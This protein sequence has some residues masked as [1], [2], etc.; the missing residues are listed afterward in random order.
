MDCDNCNA[1]S[2]SGLRNTIGTIEENPSN[3]DVQPKD[4]FW[5]ML[6]DGV[7][8]DANKSSDSLTEALDDIGKQMERLITSGSQVAKKRETLEKMLDTVGRPTKSRAGP[9]C[10]GV[11]RRQRCNSW[12]GRAWDATPLE[13]GVSIIPATPLEDGVSSH[14]EGGV[15]K[16]SPLNKS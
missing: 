15:E 10:G 4:V 16:I 12:P 2:D 6:V 13:G 11:K 1:N 7:D 5:S 9:G 8:K 3:P 14:L